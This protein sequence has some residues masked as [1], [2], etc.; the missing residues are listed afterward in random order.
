[1]QHARMTEVEVCV[2]KGCS[3]DSGDR[4]RGRKSLLNFV[5]VGLIL[6]FCLGT[7]APSD[8]SA[9]TYVRVTYHGRSYRGY[10]YV[11]RGRYYYHGNYWRRRYYRRG[12]WHY[13]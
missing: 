4:R 7:F 8:V 3:E 1:M 13:Y 12:R 10:P 5:L 11:Y 9:A 2:A 6:L